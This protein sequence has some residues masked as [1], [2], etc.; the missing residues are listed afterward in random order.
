M[1]ENSN[2]SRSLYIWDGARIFLFMINESP[3][4]IVLGIERFDAVGPL[5]VVIGANRVKI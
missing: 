3:N 4:R 1:V 5:R 2:A